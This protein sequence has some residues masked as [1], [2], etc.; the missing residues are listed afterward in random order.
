MELVSIDIDL[1]HE[2]REDRREEASCA[3][4]VKIGVIEIE[5]DD[6]PTVGSDL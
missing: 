2:L 1:F 4:F 5:K 6:H 3:S